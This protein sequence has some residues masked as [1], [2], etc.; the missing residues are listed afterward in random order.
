MSELRIEIAK[1]LGWKLFTIPGNCSYLDLTD[2][3]VRIAWHEKRGDLIVDDLN[4]YILNNELD[5][6]LTLKDMLRTVPNWPDD[7]AAVYCLESEIPENE[8]AR[9]VDCLH[10]VISEFR[11]TWGA[12]GWELAH[13]TPPQRCLAWLIWKRG[14]G[15]EE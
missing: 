4:L 7:I 5:P 11:T 14:E 13:A 1:V 10:T 2:D 8:R 6:E 9:Y 12:S 15:G 3:P